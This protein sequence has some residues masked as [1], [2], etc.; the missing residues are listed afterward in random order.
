M[1]EQAAATLSSRIAL[2]S[3]SRRGQKKGTLIKYCEVGNCLLGTYATDNVIAE[4]D[5]EIMHYT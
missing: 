2:R 3:K 1:K 5:A 4:T